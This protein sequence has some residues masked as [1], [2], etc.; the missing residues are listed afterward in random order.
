MSQSL[1]SNLQSLISNPS[2][3]LRASLPSPDLI[4]HSANQILTLAGDAPKRGATQGDLAIL[5]D[6]AI[7]I[8]GEHIIAV[9]D[10]LD[11]LSLADA[12][13]R[14]LD[15][16]GKIVLPGFVD[17][18]THAVF[19]GDRANEFDLRLRGVSYLEIQKQ[20]GGIMSTVRATRAA[21]LQELVA[22][23]RARLD[24]MLAHGT[25]TAEVK[26]G[27]G[28]DT[29]TE[30]KMLD[31]IAALDAEHPID[32]VATFLGAHVV[33]T[34]Y[35]GREDAYVDLIINEMLPAVNRRRKTEDRE[36]RSAVGGRPS[37]CDVFCDEGAFTLEQTRRILTRAREL[38]FGL[39]VHADEFANLGAATLAA[40]LG[41]ASADHLMVTRRE[42]MRAMSQANVVAVLLPGTTFGLGK[43]NFADGRAFVEE[44]VPVALATDLNPGTCWCES[45]PFVIALA[46]RYEKL[47]PAEAIVAATLNAAYS[48][49][50][51]DRVGSLV[52][53]KLA[54][55]LI[56]NVPDYRHL[57]Y[58]FGTNPI[59][60]VIKRGKISNLQSPI[61]NL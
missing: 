36:H 56:A 10:T 1:I 49:G 45:M 59:E 51:A 61:S 44:N 52:P 37:F 39:R 53:G 31:A 4:I 47:T 13:T 8:R 5:R 46:C 28:L 23:S 15:A 33:P 14:T 58:R 12:H 20:G 35:K 41:A 42:E 29:A 9:G 6:G 26:T 25:T 17:A 40:E 11:L 30:L 55:I 48:L 18:H 38:G 50:I 7:A 16:R 24:A 3:L 34:E 32:L 27:Y 54:D 22:Q 21:S 60:T 2:A 57:A 19:A 43:T